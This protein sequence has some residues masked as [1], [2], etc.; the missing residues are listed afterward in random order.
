[1]PTSNDELHLNARANAAD[2]ANTTPRLALRPKDA[3]KALGIGPRLLWSMTN[4]GEIPHV[5]MG[6]AV[7]YPVDELRRWLSEQA[8]KK[9]GRR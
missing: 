4:R 8:Q 3:T 6:R 2:D 7:V 9:G 1:M 5:R